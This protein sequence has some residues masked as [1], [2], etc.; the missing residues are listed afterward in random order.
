MSPAI[1]ER[2]IAILHLVMARIFIWLSRSF[3][4]GLVQWMDGLAHGTPS[5][6]STEFC[7]RAPSD[8][9]IVQF[10]PGHC[11]FVLLFVGRME[12]I[13]DGPDMRVMERRCG[14]QSHWQ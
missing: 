1:L 6:S 9:T 3:R 12:A 14:S 11:T 13:L 4:I 10:H 8:A 5:A 7:L 2:S